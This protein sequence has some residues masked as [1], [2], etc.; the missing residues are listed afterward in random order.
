M[1]RMKAAP[2]YWEMMVTRMRIRM[3]KVFPHPGL[4]PEGEGIVPGLKP[5]AGLKAPPALESQD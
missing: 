4:L 1:A 5:G 2:D 3:W